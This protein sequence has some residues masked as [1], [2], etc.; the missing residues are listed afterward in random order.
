[1]AMSRRWACRG[2]PSAAMLESRDARVLR[3]SSSDRP[4]RAPGVQDRDQPPDGPP[5][6]VR[7]C[8]ESVAVMAT[9]DDT[10]AARGCATRGASSVFAKRRSG[11]HELVAGRPAAASRG[12][13]Q[14]NTSREC[15]AVGH[16]PT[17]CAQKVSTETA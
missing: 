17:R 5:E 16:M 15:E 3:P 11:A 14:L 1:V 9:A 7:W 10:I 12:L 8:D 6:R 4:S 2:S 13:A